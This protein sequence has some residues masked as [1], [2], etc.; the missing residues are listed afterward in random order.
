[1]DYRDQHWPE[2]IKQLSEGV[3]MHYA[4]HA[5][6]EGKS[7][8]RVSSTLAENS[9]MTIVR[10]WE[11]GAWKADDLLVEPVYGAVWEGPGSSSTAPGYD[12]CQVACYSSVSGALLQVIGHGFGFKFRACRD[13]IDAG[14]FDKAVEDGCAL[15]GAGGMEERQA[16]RAEEWMRLISAEK[17]V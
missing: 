14:R 8:A 12:R 1:V 17:L 3:G 7:V 16:T 13:S 4:Y 11:G 2:Q 15:I 9:K 10:S 6:S 5:L